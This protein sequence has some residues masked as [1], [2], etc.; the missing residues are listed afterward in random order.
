[1]LKLR[2]KFLLIFSIVFALAG[3]VSC[4]ADGSTSVKIRFEEQS[5]SL[6][7][8]ET[9]EIEPTIYKGDAVGVIDLVWSSDDTTVVEVVNGKITAVGVGK[10]QIKVSLK[11]KPIVYD[12]VEIEVVETYLPTLKFTTE[13]KEI[14]DNEQLQMAYELLGDAE[15]VSVKWSTSDEEVAVDF[16]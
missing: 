16:E 8:G 1:M 3:L 2:R 10:T 4:T 11:D 7:K 12:K 14:K 6:L 9:Y 13:T 15:G 5:I